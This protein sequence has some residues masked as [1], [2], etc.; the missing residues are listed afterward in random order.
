MS[1][2]IIWIFAF[3]AMVSAC[4]KEKPNN[5][6]TPSPVGNVNAS[7]AVQVVN[8]SGQA[9]SGADVSVAAISAQTN[10]EGLA[11]LNSTSFPAGRALVKVEKSGYY[12]YAGV[13]EL[14]AGRFSEYI[15][16]TPKTTSGGFSSSAGGTIAAQNGGSV[17]FEPNSFIVAGGAAYT[18]PVSV[19]AMYVAPDASNAAEVMPNNFLGKNL[20]GSDKFL[21]NHGTMLVEI[22][23]SAGEKLQLAAGKTA[24]IHIPVSAQDLGSAPASIPL[25]YFNESAVRWHEDGQATLQGNEYVGNVSHFTFWMCPFVYNHY[26]LSGRLV[27]N[28]TPM[29]ATKLEV[30]NQWGAYLG[31]TTTNANGYFSG[32]IPS[33]LTFNIVVKTACN[34]ADVSFGVGPFSAAANLGDLNACTGGGAYTTIS[35]NFLNCSGTADGASW[36]RVE[37]QGFF[38]LIP[39]D[40]QGNVNASVMLC[41]GTTSVHISGV[42]LQTGN[43][44]AGQAY[45]MA[46][47]IN[48]GSQT[49]CGTSAQY[50]QFEL[51]GVP[52]Y[53]VP[54]TQYT[55]SCVYNVAQNRLTPGVV[56]NPGTGNSTHFML[57]I[58]G[59]VPGLY[60]VGGGSFNYSFLVLGNNGQDYLDV[61]LNQTGTTIGNVVSGSVANT[62]FH[63]AAGV[64]HTFNNCHFRMLVSHVN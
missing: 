58:P 61:T 3:V 28:S 51:D 4:K 57:S 41:Q 13:L 53:V 2:N 38:R 40:G 35:G 14:S 17:I 30:Y 19:S 36:A 29:P 22:T 45:P 32:M 63:D 49:V 50:C 25:Y 26:P 31:Q 11:F 27:C 39:T 64:Q 47:N 12:R 44:S 43:L 15:V 6:D 8:G 1:K 24:E 46:A 59:S 60:S 42:N 34:Q 16:L 9:I 62:T 54:T 10:S 21:E 48:F 37:S 52:Y 5:G 56:Y 23:G 55:F 7:I 20:S 33:T 18:G